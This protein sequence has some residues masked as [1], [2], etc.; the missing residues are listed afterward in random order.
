MN[1]N[2]G[3]GP[4]FHCALAYLTFIG[5]IIAYQLNKDYKDPR[6]TWHIKNMFGLLCGLFAAVW[7]QEYPIGFYVYWTVVCLWI[8][9]LIMAISNQ[10]RGI[11]YLSSAFQNWFKFLNQ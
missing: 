5:L 3:S 2:H 8:Y 9:S 1:S 4:K 10:Q 6:T 7:L 11:P